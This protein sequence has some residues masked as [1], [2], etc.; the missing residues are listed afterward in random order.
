VQED[1]EFRKVKFDKI[2]TLKPVFEKN[3]TITAA[4]AS[5]INDGA[6]AVILMSAT[7]AKS[8]G[9]KPLARVISFADAET[10]PVHF[11][12]APKDAMQ[13]TVERGKVSMDKVDLFEINEAFSAV[14]I[15][16]NKLLVLDSDKVNVNGGAVSLGHPV[17]MSGAR[18]VATLIYSLKEQ[19]KNLGL[20]GICNGGGGATSLLLEVV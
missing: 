12:V 14:T 4:N 20:A 19:N 16:N 7:R 13:K 3:G 8:L 15:L 10:E 18:L 5:S 2:P 11:A 6:C 17:G 9:I 1:E